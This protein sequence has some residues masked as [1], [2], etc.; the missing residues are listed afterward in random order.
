MSLS[1]L[2]FNISSTVVAPK[3][4]F[5]VG[6]QRSDRGVE[7]AEYILRPT[8]Y[9]FLFSIKVKAGLVARPLLEFFPVF[10]LNWGRAWPMK[11]L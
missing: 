7:V 5:K 9:L 10:F 1:K 6:G 3:L 2:P 11:S 4:L 8:F